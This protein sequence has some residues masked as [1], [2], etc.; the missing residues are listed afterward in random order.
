MSIENAGD[1]N[2]A[3]FLDKL[4]LQPSEFLS[5]SI[6]K[7]LEW[8]YERR[9][10]VNVNFRSNN[11][12]YRI[13][14]VNFVSLLKTSELINNGLVIYDE[15]HPRFE[16]EVLKNCEAYFKLFKHFT[17]VFQRPACVDPGS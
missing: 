4:L 13:R 3:G 5:L 1:A 9:L 12:N 11:M 14:A 16:R 8:Y 10:L 7:I 6:I 2:I 17:K 15:S